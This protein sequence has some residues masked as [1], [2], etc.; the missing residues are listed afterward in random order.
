MLWSDE[1][2]TVVKCKEDEEFDPDTGLA[3]CICKKMFGEAFHYIFKK[4]TKK[5]WDDI[6]K[7]KEENPFDIPNADDILNALDDILNP[8][9][10]LGRKLNGS[11]SV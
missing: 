8:L 7:A 4:Y 3:M 9:T 5:Y 10:K 11:S 1:T 6:E 2:K